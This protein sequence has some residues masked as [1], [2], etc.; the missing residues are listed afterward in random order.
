MPKLSVR[1][2]ED[3]LSYEN[4]GKSK[5]KEDLQLRNGRYVSTSRSKKIRTK[6]EEG[7]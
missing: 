2:V 5:K 3:F 6:I 7:E 1:D 4:E